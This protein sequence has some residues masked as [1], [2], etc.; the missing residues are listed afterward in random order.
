VRW[1]ADGRP[2][3]VVAALAAVA[4]E[5]AAGPVVVSAETEGASEDPIYWSSTAVAGGRF[6]VKFAWSQAAG[7]GLEREII[8]LTEL[9]RD[10]LVPY[11]PEVMAASIDP[12]LLVTRRVPGQSLF[13]VADPIGVAGRRRAGEQLAEFLAALHGPDARFR[14]TAA[15]GSWPSPQ[16]AVST[17]AL[18]AGLGRWIEPARWPDVLRWCD[19]ADAVLTGRGSP[20]VLV[21]GDLHGDNQVW[22]HDRLA[23]VIDFGSAG[24]AEP[25]YDLRTFPGPG[26]GPDLEVLTATVRHY[27]QLT[28]RPLAMDRIMAWHL[29]AA[30]GDILWRREAGLPLPDHRPVAAWIDD[31]TWRFRELGLPA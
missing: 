31:L 7:L 3:T 30:L 19:W 5:L 21:H 4:P 18:R 26:L 28:G 14:A 22:Q 25:E 8:L 15:L 2:A 24:L 29:R 17:E 20:D 12:L 23:A 10:G 1:L 16:L 9:G 6:V 11:L 13:A 27:Q